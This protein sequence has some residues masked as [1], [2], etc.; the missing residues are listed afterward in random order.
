MPLVFAGSDP[1][2]LI[3]EGS[4]LDFV[5]DPKTEDLIESEDGWFLESADSRTPVTL[6]LGSHFDAWWGEGGRGSRLAQMIS[7]EERVE[8]PAVVD[9][10]LRCMQV[11][12]DE[13]IIED[14][15]VASDEDANGKIVFTIDYTDRTSGTP[16]SAALTPMGG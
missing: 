14:L 5:F 16:Q 13:G 1:P 9:E 8:P 3:T 11:F 10:I 4:A 15:L 6:E 2:I 12:V 7:G